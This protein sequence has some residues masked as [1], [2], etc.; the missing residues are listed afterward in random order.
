MDHLTAF[1]LSRGLAILAV[2]QAAYRPSPP[3]AANSRFYAVQ[4]LQAK[5]SNLDL[6]LLQGPKR[7]AYYCQA[8]AAVAAQARGDAAEIYITAEKPRL[9]RDLYAKPEP[10][11][12]APAA[13]RVD[14]GA[15]LPFVPGA[16]SATTTATCTTCCPRRS[17][18]T[19]TRRCVIPITSC[20]FP[21]TSA[22]S[23]SR[24]GTC[25]SRWAALAPEE[26][27]A[28]LC[29]RRRRLRAAPPQ[30]PRDRAGRNAGR[31]LEAPAPQRAP[32][33]HAPGA[34]ARVLA[35][36]PVEQGAVAAQA[37]RT[38][39]R[40]RGPAVPAAA[41]ALVAVVGL[42]RRG[43][44]RQ[45]GL[46]GR[47]LPAAAAQ[48]VATWCPIDGSTNIEPRS[49]VA[50][51]PGLRLR[52]RQGLD[53]GAVAPRAL[54]VQVWRD[55]TTV[56]QSDLAY[57]TTQGLYFVDVP[58]TDN[59]TVA[60]VLANGTSGL[61]LRALDSFFASAA[62]GAG[63]VAGGTIEHM[64]IQMQTGAAS[65]STAAALVAAMTAAA[66]SSLLQD[67]AG[68][69]N[70]TVLAGLL[71]DLEL[72]LAALRAVLMSSFAQNEEYLW[73]SAANAGELARQLEATINQ[74]KSVLSTFDTDLEA[75]RQ[76]IAN[77]TVS[78][79]AR[80]NASAKWSKWSDEVG[81][82]GAS[83]ANGGLF[84]SV[85]SGYV[86]STV[87]SGY[88]IDEIISVPDVGEWVE[89]A[90]DCA[91]A[92]ATKLDF[93]CLAPDAKDCKLT[94]PSILGG[95]CYK[96]NQLFHT[97]RGDYVHTDCS[98]D[99]PIVCDLKRAAWQ[100]KYLMRYAL[101][102]LLIFVIP[103]GTAGLLAYGLYWLV[104]KCRGERL[105]TLETKYLNTRLKKAREEEERDKATTMQLLAD[106]DKETSGRP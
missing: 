106:D 3:A 6:I 83:L 92:V 105:V 103:I 63:G 46:R 79:E 24:T 29:R 85:L 28:Q 77:I 20:S 87:P 80:Q 32:G 93:D 44:A 41:H 58:G 98:K 25:C 36:A 82:L 22:A 89:K 76:E 35:Q 54:R 62:G 51:E 43:D 99:V 57:P 30:Q 94:Q 15:G 33:P 40:A 26:A 95:F 52:F 8:P 27:G 38:E 88:V 14:A 56:A 39:R 16:G 75:A 5:S 64:W 49:P 19:R 7:K 86:R 81:S 55:N 1:R 78:D 60:A 84:Q 69:D 34:L 104:H 50:G 21:R 13:G 10:A 2:T 73:R 59:P 66:T 9:G 70:A 71:N 65:A 97:C 23:S 53:A 72:E 90:V 68:A 37:L 12:A 48:L 47:A 42:S 18:G 91:A 31:V 17:A 102:V 61:W 100:T 67:V 96:E 11:S 101:L 74:T 4:K 45:R